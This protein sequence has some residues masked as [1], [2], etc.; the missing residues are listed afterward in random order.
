M[1]PRHCQAMCY[2]HECA[3]LPD[4][5]TLQLQ[6][7]CTWDLSWCQIYINAIIHCYQFTFVWSVFCLHFLIW[8]LMFVLS[9]FYQLNSCHDKKIFQRKND[10]F[11]PNIALLLQITITVAREI[12]A[13]ALYVFNVP[14]VSLKQV[15]K[16][17][18][19]SKFLN[20]YYFCQPKMEEWR[21]I[22]LGP[23]NKNK[24]Q[25]YFLLST[26]Q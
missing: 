16:G 10:S 14:M 13:N 5:L 18:D 21:K 4:Y 12:I 11:S 26:I 23:F 19:V 2:S 7:C 22:R 25:K 3:L 1:R 17:V 9:I 15:F 20:K 6:Q 8:R 24:S